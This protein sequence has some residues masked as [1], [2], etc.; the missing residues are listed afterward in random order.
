MGVY[1]IN[2][3]VSSYPWLQSVH[4][5][6]AVLITVANQYHVYRFPGL[7]FLWSLWTPCSFCNNDLLFFCFFFK[8]VVVGFSDLAWP[9]CSHTGSMA[10]WTQQFNNCW[11][12][13]REMS[14]RHTAATLCPQNKSYWFLVNLWLW[15]KCCEI[16][17]FCDFEK[18]YWMDHHEIWYKQ[19]GHPQN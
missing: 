10:H 14:Y 7:L 4:H 3:H 2:A 9:A 6:Q 17:I 13:C 12:V 18:N 11:M 16:D 15:T 5:V 1:N 19:S 8:L